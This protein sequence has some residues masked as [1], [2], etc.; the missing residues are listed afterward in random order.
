MLEWDK[1]PREPMLLNGQNA[2]VKIHECDMNVARLQSEV[3]RLPPGDLRDD[4]NRCARGWLAVRAVLMGQADAPY[5][6]S[7]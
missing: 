4:K 2:N 5:P 1:G 7:Q 3:K 6:L